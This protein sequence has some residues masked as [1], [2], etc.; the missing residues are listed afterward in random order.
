MIHKLIWFVCI[1]AAV[2]PFG[3]ILD[4]AIR[5]LWPR[6]RREYIRARVRHRN[7]TYG[8]RPWPSRRRVKG[9]SYPKKGPGFKKGRRKP[10]RKGAKKPGKRKNR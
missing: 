9:M 10:K 8:R 3:L 1:Y 2:A 7:E 4:V 6:I 5:K